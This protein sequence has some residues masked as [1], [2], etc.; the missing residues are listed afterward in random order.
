MTNYAE[1][2]IHHNPFSRQRRVFES[3]KVQCRRILDSLFVQERHRRVRVGNIPV[4]V[5]IYDILYV[6][7]SNFASKTD[8]RFI[9]INKLSGIYI[10]RIFGIY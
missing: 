5:I 2:F 10:I 9:G 1:D 4:L 8:N 3:L 6:V 7:I